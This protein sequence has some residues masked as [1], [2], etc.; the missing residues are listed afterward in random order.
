ML[1]LKCPLVAAAY[2]C[3]VKS[4]INIENMENKSILFELSK[5][6]LVTYCGGYGVVI[7]RKG[8][9]YILLMQMSVRKL[10]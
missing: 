4:T 1:N 3:G 2:F 7:L 5:K 10:I 6:D 9:A 8:K